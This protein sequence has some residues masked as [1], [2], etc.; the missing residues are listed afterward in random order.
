MSDLS[1][2]RDRLIKA[3]DEFLESIKETDYDDMRID[4]FGIV[5][6]CTF[7]NDDGEESEAPFQWFEARR[8]HV[9]IGVLKTC[10]LEVEAVYMSGSTDPND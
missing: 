7:N 5:A 4:T 10:L 3:V 9:Q 1:H 8:H 6:V 2:E